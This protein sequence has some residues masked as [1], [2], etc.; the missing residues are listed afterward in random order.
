MCSLFNILTFYSSK[1]KFCEFL[2]V[3]LNVLVFL[4]FFLANCATGTLNITTTTTT[5]DVKFQL[6]SNCSLTVGGN[7]S[8]KGLITGLTPGAVY[9]IV[10]NCSGSCNVSNIATSKS[11]YFS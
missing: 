1:L 2:T 11:F 9:H 5:A 3:V 10:L 8:E 7:M 4:F 6:D